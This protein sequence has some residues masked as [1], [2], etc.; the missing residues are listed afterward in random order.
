MDLAAEGVLSLFSIKNRQSGADLQVK[1]LENQ[2]KEQQLQTED[3]K[4]RETDK[5]NKM[6]STQRA[7]MA[8][9][10]VSTSSGAFR[11]LTVGDFEN[12]QQDLNA[13]TLN[14]DFAMTKLDAQIGDVRE[15]ERAGIYGDLMSFGK[16]F[17]NSL[18]MLDK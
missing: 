2:R 4:I 3:K 9:R 8:A 17:Y 14:L 13:D 12:Y 7:M 18:S 5:L 6:L 11:G 15:K 1:E 10:G 16:D